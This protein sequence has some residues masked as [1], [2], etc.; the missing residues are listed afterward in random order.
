M[1]LSWSDRNESHGSSETEAHVPFQWIRICKDMALGA[2]AAIWGPWEKGWFE[3]TANT[4]E[5]AELRD[6]NSGS[7]DTVWALALRQMNLYLWVVGTNEWILL[8]LFCL[9]SGL[10]AIELNPWILTNISIPFLLLRTFPCV[11]IWNIYLC[12]P[13][14]P[15]PSPLSSYRLSVLPQSRALSH[16]HCGLHMCFP[17]SLRPVSMSYPLYIS[18]ASHVIWCIRITYMFSEWLSELNE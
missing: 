6:R 18:E 12:F 3:N 14:Q 13:A 1:W 5:R 11:S 2:K 8:F 7:C 17:R 16:V 15:S 4:W 9:G 10:L